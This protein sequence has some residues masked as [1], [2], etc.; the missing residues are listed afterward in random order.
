VTGNV[1]SPTFHYYLSYRGRRGLFLHLD[2][3]RIETPD[4]YASLLVEELLEEPWLLVVEWADRVE[5]LLPGPIL[6]IRLSAVG[7]TARRLAWR[8]GPGFAPPGP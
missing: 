6:G 2:A 3:H 8:P 1:K 7:E 5:G 4:D